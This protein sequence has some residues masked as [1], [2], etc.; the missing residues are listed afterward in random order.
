MGYEQYVPHLVE[1]LAI[2]I[3]KVEA[4]ALMIERLAERIKVLEEGG[5]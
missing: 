1:A 2:T 4:Q 3:D 5:L